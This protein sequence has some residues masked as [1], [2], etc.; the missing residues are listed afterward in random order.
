[1]AHKKATKSATAKKRA[2]PRRDDEVIDPPFPHFP[3]GESI[4]VEAMRIID[5]E[6]EEDY[7]QARTNFDRIATGWEVIFDQQI[8]GRQVAL[9]M[10]WLKISRDLHHPKRDNAVDI[11]GYAGLMERVAGV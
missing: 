1:M 9:A 5:G 6:R 4:L 7:G 3:T 8:T 10:I 2:T 11:A